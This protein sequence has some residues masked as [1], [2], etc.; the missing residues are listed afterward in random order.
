MNAAKQAAWLFCVLI[1]LAGSGLYYAS[2]TAISRLDEQTL[3]KS[4]DRVITNLIFKRFDDMGRL[5]SH[6]QSPEVQH[7]PASDTHFFTSPHL[8]L[9]QTDQPAWEINAKHGQVIKNG[10]QIIFTHEVIIHQNKSEHNQESTLRSEE[11]TYFPKEKLATSQSAVSFEQPGRTVRSA[12]MKA[13][14]ADKRVQL[15]SQAHATFEP[16]H[17]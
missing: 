9:T 17:G 12:G 7:I 1:A 5:I 3:S 14:L 2:S 11:I 4:A 8:T 15:L 13:Y 16:N 10:E 6:L